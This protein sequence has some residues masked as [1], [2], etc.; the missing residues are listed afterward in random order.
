MERVGSTYWRSI[1]EHDPG[2]CPDHPA[3]D[4]AL[5]LVREDVLAEAA[6]CVL[7]LAD[8]ARAR[9]PTGSA[10]SIATMIEAD[11]H[12]DPSDRR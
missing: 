6:G 11:G 10:I 8:R 9:D 7:V 2:E 1:G 3:D 12:D 5:E 4:E